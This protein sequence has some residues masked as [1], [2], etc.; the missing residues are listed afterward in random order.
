MEDNKK[1]LS[2]AG[3]IISADLTINQTEEVR[4]FYKQV[5]GWEHSDINMGDYSDYMMTTKEGVPV[6]GICHQ[7]GENAGLP[8]VWLVY[9]QVNNLEK[10]LEM[11][12]NLGGKV[13]REPESG[14]T[15][16]GSFA[17]IEY[18]AGAICALCQ[19]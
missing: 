15:A 6:V 7:T 2:Q 18:P 16:C 3:T 9:F 13:L 5:I 4:D 1:L 19:M 8:P 17:V 10:S 14:S 12:R 11:C